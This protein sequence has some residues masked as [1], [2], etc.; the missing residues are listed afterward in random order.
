MKSVYEIIFLARAHSAKA[1]FPS[2]FAASH[3]ASLNPCFAIFPIVQISEGLSPS[4]KLY[5]GIKILHRYDRRLISRILIFI[6]S[7]NI[8]EGSEIFPVHELIC[9]G[10]YDVGKCTSKVVLQRLPEIE[11]RAVR[12][13]TKSTTPMHQERVPNSREL[14][15]SRVR[16]EYGSEKGLRL[17]VGQSRE[18]TA[19][20]R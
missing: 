14:L 17:P 13:I 5:S 12:V 9:D 7:K 10:E 19:R 8:S 15:R 16:D 11:G 6:Q 18:R 2:A 20:H 1:A 4:C 3:S